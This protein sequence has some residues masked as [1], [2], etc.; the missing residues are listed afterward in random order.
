MVSLADKKS[1]HYLHSTLRERIV[2]HVFVG[3]VLRELWSRDIFDV[4][5]LRPE[6]D[7]GG[8][9]LVMNRGNIERHIQFTTSL[10]DGKAADIKASLKLMTKPGGCVIWIL[11]TPEL[12]LHS[13]RWLGG[14]P[15]QRL[16]DIL[17]M[18]VAKHTKGNAGGEK[19]KRPGHRII[20]VS[21]F[22]PP[23]SLNKIL[24]RLFGALA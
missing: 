10:V 8:Y 19:G 5:V 15:G 16:P 17:S 13:Y 23:C 20:P 14:A 9:D 21:Q 3:D 22:D 6:F 24:E 7:A 11:V 2:E 4:E 12:V 1:K 18:K